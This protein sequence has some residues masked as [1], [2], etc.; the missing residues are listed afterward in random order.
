MMMSL[1]VTDGG[2]PPDL[3]PRGRPSSPNTTVRVSLPNKQRTVLTVQAGVTLLECLTKALSKRG[4]VPGCC[5]VYAVTNGQKSLVGWDS[6]LGSLQAE[7]LRVELLDDITL[8]TH[9]FVRKTYYRL[10][11]C[12]ICMKFLFQGFRCQTCGCKFHQ[13]CSTD[14]PMVCVNMH[15]MRL[16]EIAPG[17]FPQDLP[18]V[19]QR[20]NISSMPQSAFLPQSAKPGDSQTSTFSFPP[21]K[22][23][24]GQLTSRDRSSSTPNIAGIITGP[25]PHSELQKLLQNQME[26]PPPILVEPGL[27]DDTPDFGQSRP[28]GRLHRSPAIKERKPSSST[29]PARIFPRGRDSCY[30]WEI[31]EDEVGLM[32][33]I[34][35]GS[36]GTVYRGKWHGDV[37]VKI[38][39]VSDPTP[40]QLQAFKNE[41]AVLR[42]TRHMNVLLFMGYITRPHLAIVTQWCEGSSLYRHLHVLETAYQLLELIDIARQIA[43][44]MDYLHAKNI[45]H[46]DLKSH[47]IFLHEGL[48]VKIGDFGLATVKAHWGE[49]A[50]HCSGSILWMAPEVIRMRQSDPYSYQSDVYAY[51]IVLFE[52]LARHLPYSHVGNRDQ[53]LFM[54]GSGILTP[55]LDKV[56]PNCPK[57]MR[58]LMVDCL[59]RNREERPLFPQI[60]AIIEV[61]VSSLPKIRRSLSEPSLHRAGLDSPG[62]RIAGGGGFGLMVG[63]EVSAANCI[64][65]T[66][67]SCI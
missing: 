25:V 58:R 14:V 50:S 9:N 35:S 20:Q 22:G 18:V 36:F 33:R 45:I 63:R 15:R 66:M 64:L 62:P 23:E 57:T 11:F 59:K 55:D 7:E 39:K 28:A 54:V 5:L 17:G 44:G 37:A 16:Y 4:L 48:T 26:L 51:G 60:L 47:N 19:S 30:H 43:Q 29:D 13:R 40:Q 67:N 65:G 1:E 49:Q 24:N 32:E 46:R 10:A 8:T 34:G 12:D 53:I 38:L 52:L 56:S 2:S 6:D 27:S 31:R 61:L 42:K 21:V 3:S 41:V